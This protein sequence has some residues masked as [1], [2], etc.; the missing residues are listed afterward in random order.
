[1]YIA[2]IG[3]W[4]LQCD[5]EAT[6][7]AFLRVT[8]GSPESCGCADCLNFAASRERVYPS[9]CLSIFNEL[10]ID[11]HKESEIWHTHRDENGLHHYGGFFHFIGAIESGRDVMVKKSG[12]RTYDFET[13]G[14]RFEW[15][16]AS[17]TALVPS[18]F[19]G[20]PVTQF[21]FATRIPWIIEMPEPD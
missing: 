16:L 9:L 8:I 19:A 2:Q 21:E 3:R 7:E 6:R 13:I 15:G 1:M 20:L 12:Y 10:G 11:S 5:P 17:E 18:S 14:E 4:K